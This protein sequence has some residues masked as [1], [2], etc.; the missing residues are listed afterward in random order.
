[1]P[2]KRIGIGECPRLY[3]SAPVGEIGSL[4]LG[5]NVWRLLILVFKTA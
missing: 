1:M 5:E 2:L 4:W 3:G